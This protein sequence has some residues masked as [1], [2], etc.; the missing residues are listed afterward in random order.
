[1]KYVFSKEKYIQVEGMKKYEIRKSWADYC[2]GEEVDFSKES[3]I[4]C[5]IITKGNSKH[6]VEK[7]WCEVVE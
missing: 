3:Y 5:G 7:R 1:M 6:A 2:D 4:E